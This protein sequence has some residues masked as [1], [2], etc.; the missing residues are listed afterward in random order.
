MP[1]GLFEKKERSGV[2]WRDHSLSIIIGLI[3]LV[4][5]IYALWSGAYVF[6]REQPLGADV[7][8]W[9]GGFWMW[10]GWEY[11]ISVVADT[12]GVLLIVLLS[13]WLREVGSAED[14]GATAGGQSSDRS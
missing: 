11:N 3:L 10:W 1:S 12:Y 2:W 14:K 6:A 8:P 4:Q 7:A 13:K 5:T 9:S